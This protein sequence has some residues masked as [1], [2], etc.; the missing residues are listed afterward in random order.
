MNIELSTDKECTD[1]EV[2]SEM[3]DQYNEKIVGP[4]HDKPLNLYVK[5]DSGNV[6]GGLVGVTYWGWLYVDYLVVD[7]SQRGSGLGSK[8]LDRAEDEALRRG[9]EGVHLDS[10][11]FQAL[12]FYTRHGY[13]VNSTIENLPKGHYKYQLIK[14]L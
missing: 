1:K 8:L 11:D 3:L 2:V 12:D 13:R 10:H 5:D 9:C 7:E 6:L 14:E 4:Y